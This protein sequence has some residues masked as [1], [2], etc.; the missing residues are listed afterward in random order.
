M[1]NKPLF[2]IITVC[3]NSE[4]TIKQTIES[5][6][7]QTCQDFEYIIVD[8]ISTD[9]TL[10]IIK[11][12][13][14]QFK[15]KMKWISEKDEGI[16][17]AMNKAISMSKGRIIGIIN[18]DD[19]YAIDALEHVSRAYLKNR[20]GGVFYGIAR[21]IS[22]E[23]EFKLVRV[24]HAHLYKYMMKHPT[25]FV[26][27]MYYDKYGIFN[28]T[29]RVVADYDF[30]IRVKMGGGEFIPLDYVLASYRDGGFND[31][32]G[33]FF[34]QNELNN[35]IYRHRLI[36]TTLF[37]AK[38]VRILFVAI[39]KSIHCQIKKSLYKIKF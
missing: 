35:M 29:Y 7:N 16:Y 27:K 39:T 14:P 12:H 2:T 17:F 26:Q 33:Y 25:C 15:G 13:D 24:H 37:L 1:N 4:K 6:L 10:Q 3:L 22:N 38:K 11:E 34:H 8:G 36:T 20:T 23:Q 19:W 28:T 9:S 21:A 30:L 5:V 18:S 32:V 31:N